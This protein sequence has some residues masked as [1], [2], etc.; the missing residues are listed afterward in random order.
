MSEFEEHTFESSSHD[1]GVSPS[2]NYPMYIPPFSPPFETTQQDPYQVQASFQMLG[3]PYT[4]SPVYTG[5]PCGQINLSPQQTMFPFSHYPLESAGDHNGPMSPQEYG[6][7]Q[8]S[9][10]PS[11][12]D[13]SA[14]NMTASESFALHTTPADVSDIPTDYAGFDG[15]Q[16][17]F[18]TPSRQDESQSVT[19]PFSANLSNHGAF[20][21][22]ESNDTFTQSYQTSDHQASENLSSPET[23]MY[24]QGPHQYALSN[25]NN[26]EGKSQIKSVSNPE[27][28]GLGGSMFTDNPDNFVTAQASRNY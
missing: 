5:T 21:S 18:T 24:L 14:A 19:T 23:A 28:M 27:Y 26:L 4:D 15:Y 1:A 11:S 22:F 9:Y 16:M 3:S 2:I 8:G 6:R 13:T 17:N 20:H 10:F 25:Q 12:I 7:S